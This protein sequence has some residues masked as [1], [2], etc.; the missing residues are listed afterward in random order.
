MK[1]MS[2]I[3]RHNTS[4]FKGVIAFGLALGLLLITGL[5]SCNKYLDAKPSAQ[6][7]I[8]S[9]LADCQAL[10]DNY[11][12][13]HTS[14]LS[15]ESTADNFYY[16]YTDWQSLQTDPR[17]DYVWEPQ[18]NTN[19][20]AWQE[21]YQIVLYANQALETLGKINPA[22]DQSNWNFV[23]GQALFYRAYSFYNLAQAW[24]KPYGPS[25]ST[26]LGIPIRLT[27]DISVVSI[28]GT[29]EQTYN[30]II[31]DLTAAIELL[32]TGQPTSIIDKSRP[33][34]A[35]AYAALARVFL[36]MGD[37]VNAGVN[38]DNSLKIYSTLID[39]NL[40][41][42]AVGFPFHRFN[43]EVLFDNGVS[44]IALLASKA[45][46]DSNLYAS[47]TANDLR[48]TCFFRQNSGANA[49]TYQFIGGYLGSPSNQVFGG[50]AT[51]EMYLIRAECYAR[52]GDVASA[53]TDLNTLLSK[54]YTPG[55]TATAISADDALA[56]IIT[57]RR[58]ELIFR[59]L[60]WT[61]LRRLN[62]DPKFAVT[63]TRVL[64][65]TTYSLPPNDPRYVWLIP[66]GVEQ[67]V[68]L[69]Q[70]PR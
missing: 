53:M 3:N 37:Y 26:D 45:K 25:A 55:Y 59:G 52:A 7:V 2:T 5:N 1:I 39:Y 16:T 41:N 30:Q 58:K 10:L 63:L 12:S 50:L 62:A 15:T 49:G 36:S 43:D 9:T 8:P 21:Q 17:N 60:R 28:R 32:P 70:N 46:I 22:A 57:E 56:Q 61:D 66:S 51:D 48:K 4:P 31:R 29:V 40:A 27:P 24:A 34:K 69:P 19:T 20:A 67:V 64:N 6:L 13:V 44:V 18:A 33:S 65:G 35:A 14:L 38:A 11:F 68:P 47:Y 23:K 54:R 42:P